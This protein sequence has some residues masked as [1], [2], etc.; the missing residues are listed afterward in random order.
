MF[1][2]FAFLSNSISRRS[3]RRSKIDVAAIVVD[4]DLDHFARGGPWIKSS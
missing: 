4:D 2:F 3:F 1:S